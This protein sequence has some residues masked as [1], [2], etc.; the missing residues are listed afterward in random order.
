MADVIIVGDGGHSK[1]VREC[2]EQQGVDTI[3]GILDNK[4]TSYEKNGAQ[5][6]AP[7]DDFEQYKK[8]TTLWFIAIGDNKARAGVAAKLGDVRYA[9]I[10]H[11]TAIISKAATIEP[12][13]VIMPLAVV[14]PDSVIGAHTIINTGAIVEHDVIISEAAHV[15]PRATVTGGVKI[16]TGVHVGASAVVNPGVDLGAYSVIGAGA[17]VVGDTEAGMTYVGVPARKLER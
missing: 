2:L 12:G 17:V 10:I 1:V 16:G 13:T 8:D 5:F 9:T 6:R 4:Y 15:S 7:F 3:I 14:Q 11:P